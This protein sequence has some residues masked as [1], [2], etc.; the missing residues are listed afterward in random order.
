M[1][2][3]GFKLLGPWIRIEWFKPKVMDNIIKA[4][5]T[6][7]IIKGESDKHTLLKHNVTIQIIKGESDKHTLTHE[8][9]K[10]R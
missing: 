3:I 1:D 8:M 7:Q 9:K 5:K 2:K 4:Y 6:I 10:Y